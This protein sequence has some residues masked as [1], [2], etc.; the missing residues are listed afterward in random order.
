MTAEVAPGE[1]RPSEPCLV[2]D[3][4]RGQ[5]PPSKFLR[6]KGNGAAGRL[7]NERLIRRVV[8]IAAIAAGLRTGQGKI[9]GPN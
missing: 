6:S 1:V 5:E 2:H 8:V 9:P 3:R 7:P 4:Q